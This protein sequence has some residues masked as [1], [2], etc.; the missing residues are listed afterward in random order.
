MPNG[1]SVFCCV[2]DGLL[3]TSK[4]RVGALQKLTAMLFTEKEDEDLKQHIL[5]CL[6]LAAES[7]AVL[8]A[9]KKFVPGNEKQLQNF[10]ASE[11]VPARQGHCGGLFGSAAAPRVF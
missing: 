4:D 5:I 11:G 7:Q 8:E 1:F 3:Q 9:Q 2:Q 6:T 10:L